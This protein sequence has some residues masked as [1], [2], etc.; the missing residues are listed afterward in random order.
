M[1]LRH[2]LL[3]ALFI[4]CAVPAAAQQPPSIPD[5]VERVALA[6]V[7]D[8]L[9][10]EKVCEGSRDKETCR[11]FEKALDEL[12]A[13]E[14][15]STSPLY[16]RPPLWLTREARAKEVAGKVEKLLPKIDGK[17]ERERVAAEVEKLKRL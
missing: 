17:K 9:F 2:I 5:I 1:N 6:L 7:D 15:Q 16:S 3:T 12:L 14:K 8:G 10:T 11:G 13:I 4:L